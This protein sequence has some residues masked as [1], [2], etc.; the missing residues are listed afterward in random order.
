MQYIKEITVDL[1]GEMYFSYITA[2]QGDEKSRFVKITFLSGGVAFVPPEGAIAALRCKKPD[3]TFAFNDATINEDGTITAE[4]T[5]NMLA[6][7]GNCR[8]EVTVYDDGSALTSIPFIVKVTPGAVDP[9]VES[10]NEYTALT[11]ALKK[12][13]DV[14]GVSAAALEEATHAFQ[15]MAE[16]EVKYGAHTVANALKGNLSGEIVTINDVSPIEHKMTVKVK[17]K[18]LIPYP[19]KTQSTTISGVT[20]TDNGDGTIT[21]S[22]T[23][24]E[25][26][27]Y[28]PIDTS[29]AF[30]LSSGTYVL[31]GGLSS[32]VYL[33]GK[34]LE[35]DTISIVDSG[36]GKSFTIT[37]A[38]HC[39][40]NIRITSG[41]TVNDTIKPQLEIGTVATEYAPY[42]DPS[43]VKLK[44]CGKNLFDGEWES[45]S[46]NSTTG[47]KI[48]GST[49]IRTVNYI[50]VKPNTTYYFS[51]TA[52]ANY[53]PYS[54]DKDFTFIA[55]K[56]MK[57]G[58]FYLTMG[59][60]EY[61][62]IIVQ[63]GNTTPPLNAQI[64]IGAAATEY[65]EFKGITE[66]TPTTDGTVEN[67]ISVYPTMLLFT[68]TANTIIECEYNKDTNKV[69]ESLVNAII[70]LGGN[71]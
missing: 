41:T 16:L 51:F 23:A 26:V 43:T 15:K 52:G 58:S 36:N 4:L 64:E 22:G 60:N 69:I 20:F 18:N 35:D 11:A 50:P 49:N 19:Y 3:G 40:F 62:L 24:T 30:L 59:E 33:Q 2:V 37:E 28:S 7:V 29:T 10:T 56:G 34:V 14:D 38:M 57:Q 45:G 31:S 8:C 63:Y 42:I 53:F 65:E 46:I 17:G 71:V 21:V 39:R 9:D 12:V 66:Y 47:A 67:V 32:L 44:T 68:D 55:Y 5:G 61:Y 70:S 48:P 6:A 54:Y 25:E 1:S 13:Q 27:I